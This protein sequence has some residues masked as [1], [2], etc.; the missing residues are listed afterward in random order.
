VEEKKTAAG[1]ESFFYPELII[2]N[3]HGFGAGYD[4][5]I[6]PSYFE[7]SITLN[8]FERKL[9]HCSIIKCP[10]SLAELYNEKQDSQP[11]KD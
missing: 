11:D 2:H 5:S 9:A 3:H 8:E 6:D 4:R 1:W 10:K 7:K